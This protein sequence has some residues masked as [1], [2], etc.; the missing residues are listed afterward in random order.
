M[1]MKVRREDNEDN[2]RCQGSSL[3]KRRVVGSYQRPKTGVHS[4]QELIPPASG[5]THPNEV[6]Y[7]LVAYVAKLF[8]ERAES[9]EAAHELRQHRDE[10]NITILPPMIIHLNKNV[11]ISRQQRSGTLETYVLAVERV[12]EQPEQD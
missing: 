4:R 6:D 7:S 12:P 5:L 3:C 2:D 9:S 1:M 11:A 10:L 8:V